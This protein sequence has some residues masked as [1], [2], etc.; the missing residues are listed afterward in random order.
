MK[1]NVNGILFIELIYVDNHAYWLKN[2]SQLVWRGYFCYYTFK[3]WLMFYIVR[4]SYQIRKSGIS[5]YSRLA[6]V[7]FKL[8]IQLE[9]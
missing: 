4:M 3:F 6:Q 1:K 5:Y 8:S 7:F 9:V 2:S